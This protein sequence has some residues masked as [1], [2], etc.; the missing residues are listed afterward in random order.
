M[1]AANDD[2]SL[3]PSK[4]S[5]RHP[6]DVESQD[7]FVHDDANGPIRV[8][9]R[10]LLI[11]ESVSRRSLP[12]KSAITPNPTSIIAALEELASQTHVVNRHQS[13]QEV[14][15]ITECVERH[16]LDYLR[17]ARDLKVNRM[18]MTPM[19]IQKKIV[20]FLRSI[21]IEL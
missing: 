6:L 7:S 20:K 21:N 5:S 15:W 11:G 4:E 2:P 18:Q 14:L 19:Q 16:G 10:A 13:E 9:A 3:V 17:M 12:T 8:D 1:Q